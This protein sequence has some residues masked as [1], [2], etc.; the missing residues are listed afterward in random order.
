M[1]ENRPRSWYCS[2]TKVVDGGQL[3]ARTIISDEKLKQAIDNYGVNTQSLLDR[4]LIDYLCEMSFSQIDLVMSYK[5][6]FMVLQRSYWYFDINTEKDVYVLQKMLENDIEFKYVTTEVWYG[7]TLYANMICFVKG[8]FSYMPLYM[9]NDGVYSNI[10]VKAYILLTNHVKKWIS[11]FD[12]MKDELD[13]DN[14]K[15][16]FY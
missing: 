11:L 8:V 3:S 6:D 10:S 4:R 1:T 16:R 5:P 13:L 7:Q 14:K 9:I 12:V 15:Q 2:I